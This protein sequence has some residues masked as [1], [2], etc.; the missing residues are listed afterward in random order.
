MSSAEGKRAASE[1]VT[2]A[3]LRAMKEAGQPVACLTAYDYGFAAACER[4]G[5]DLLLVGDSLGMVVQGQETTLPVTVDDVVYHTRCVARACR[6]SLVVA[7]LPFMSHTDVASGLHTAGRLVKE[8]GARMVKLE[9]GADQA[10][11]VERLAE[12]GIPVCG[13][14]GL[15]PQR[16][17]KLGGYRVQGRALVDAEAMESD[18]RAL[19]AAGA[20]L[21]IVECVPAP[22]ARHLSAQLGIPVVGIGAGAGC[23]GQILVLHDALGVSAQP[24]RFARDFSDGAGSVQQALAAYVD[25]VRTGTFPGPEHEFEA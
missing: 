19:E 18:A 9:G 17:H 8:G 15:K 14:L 21:I 6:R 10:A 24:P 7:D 22:L 3:R 20:D 25:A 23:D 13:H 5:V 16:I 4:A 12:S 11:L 1:A 2:V